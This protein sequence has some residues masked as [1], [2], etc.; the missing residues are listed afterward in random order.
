MVV[1]ANRSDVDV[2][3][4]EVDVGLAVVL[5]TVVDVS[6]VDVS[7][8]E[9]D[10]GLV[11]VLE[12]AVD[13]SDNNVCAEGVDIEV[14]VMLDKVFFADTVVW[15]KVLLKVDLLNEDMPNVVV[16]SVAVDMTIVT[17]SVEIDVLVIERTQVLQSIGQ[18]VLVG[19][20]TI[21]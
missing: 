12:T 15:L 9:V 19:A 5:E 13:V 6:D 14:K 18:L 3:V 16:L 4:I 8:I 21:V 2:S 11:A 17:G 1:S 10:V 20:P 7:V